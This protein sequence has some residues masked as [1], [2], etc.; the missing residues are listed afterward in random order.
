MVLKRSWI[1]PS[2]RR[3]G[4]KPIFCLLFLVS[5]A[6]SSTAQVRQYDVCTGDTFIY[7]PAYDSAMYS[8]NYGDGFSQSSA[9]PMKYVYGALGTYKVTVER[10]L[11]SKTDTTRF[12]VNVGDVPAPGFTLSAACY[13]YHF[14]NTCPDTLMINGGW[15][16]DFGDGTTSGEKSPSH[17]YQTTGYYHVTLQFVRQNK[18]SN[19]STRSFTVNAS[20][21]PSFIYH[22][23]GN[24]AIFIPLDTSGAFYH[25]DFGDKDTTD[26]IMPVHVFRLSGKYLVSLLI[27]TRGGCT[28]YYTDTITVNSAGIEQPFA[29]SNLFQAYPNPFRGAL[30]IHYELT[31][32][33]IVTLNL[34]DVAGRLVATV[35]DG[36]RH[37][38]RYD[39]YIHPVDYGLKAGYCRC[40]WIDGD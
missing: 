2:Y 23:N 7:P 35:G 1:G 5:I 38:G 13:L 10:T 12:R 34:F 40:C 31:G 3:A 27:R 20:I 19:R 16:W 18:C 26:S 6:S 4:Y 33:K 37:S 28:T 11:N 14:Q 9:Y 22:S 15:L 29:N 30:T 17:L 21:D 32:N 24:S 39:V 36:L 8:I 25:W